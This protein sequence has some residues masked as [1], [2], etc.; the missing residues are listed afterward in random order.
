MDLSSTNTK[1][2]IG[3]LVV[4]VLGGYYLFFDTSTTPGT[5]E[6][7]TI[8]GP[9][10]EDTIGPGFAPTTSFVNLTSGQTGTA[11][12]GVSVTFRAGSKVGTTLYATFDV[13]RVLSD[14]TAYNFTTYAM[15]LNQSHV[16]ETA[17]VTVSV[18]SLE[19]ISQGVFNVMARISVSELNVSVS[20]VKLKYYNTLSGNIN[21]GSTATY[22]I[23]RSRTGVGIKLFTNSTVSKMTI[24]GNGYFNVHSKFTDGTWSKAYGA[25]TDPKTYEITFTPPSKPGQLISN[26]ELW[27]SWSSACRINELE[28]YK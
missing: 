14:G 5:I 21:D 7:A 10:S 23:M 24:K 6:E 3:V 2:I 4:A 20:E 16:N 22:T 12:G 25:R 19:E 26:F 9:L 18:V 11:P 13:G 8:V 27:C 17:G 15:S 28:I 1:I